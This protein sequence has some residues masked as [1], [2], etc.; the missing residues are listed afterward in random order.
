MTLG[1]L[2]AEE[3]A[4]LA[5]LLA[6]IADNLSNAPALPMVD[7]DDAAPLDLAGDTADLG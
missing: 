5:Q 1:G 2:S 6:R 4:L 3:R 7:A